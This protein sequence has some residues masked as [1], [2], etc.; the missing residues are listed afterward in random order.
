MMDL[1]P[2]YLSSPF[3]RFSHGGSHFL[4]ESS[5]FLPFELE[6]CLSFC[7]WSP[8]LR[9]RIEFSRAAILFYHTGRVR[10]CYLSAFTFL[11]GSPDLGR[12]IEVLGTLTYRFLE[13]L[14]ATLLY[15]PS[16]WYP[17]S[18]LFDPSESFC[19]VRSLWIAVITEF[20]AP[21]APSC[22]YCFQRFARASFLNQVRA[23]PSMLSR[24]LPC[25]KT[26]WIRVSAF[27]GSLFFQTKMT[28]RLS[29]S[30]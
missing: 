1:S 20:F 19:L 23:C 6:A 8:H 21:L 26:G 11:K 17:S 4:P 9:F 14:A 12:W 18:L 2:A 7:G 22:K 28:D 25:G 29:L 15:R 5:V 16:S 13:C 10:I 27:H 24:T 30:S 3:D